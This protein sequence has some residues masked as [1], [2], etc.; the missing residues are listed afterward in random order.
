MP[1]ST[2]QLIDQIERILKNYIPNEDKAISAMIEITP[3][4][5][6]IIHDELDDMAKRTD[7][8]IQEVFSR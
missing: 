6:A 1:K 4:I 7:K 5:Y 3:I 2:S 8:I